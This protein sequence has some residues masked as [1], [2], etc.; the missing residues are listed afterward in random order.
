MTFLKEAS[1]NLV[2]FFAT[3]LPVNIISWLK[4]GRQGVRS[5]SLYETDVGVKYRHAYFDSAR[6]SE[7][8][9]DEFVLGSLDLPFSDFL[10]PPDLLRNAYTNCGKSILESPHYQL[11]NELESGTFSEAGS[12]Y[13]RRSKSGTLD[14]RSPVNVDP[15][16]IREK[17]K[18]RK[19]E[20]LR[21]GYLTVTVFRLCLK[22]RSRYVIAD[23]KHRI[24]MAALLSCPQQLLLRRIS[25]RFSDDPFF[26]RIYSFI[27][28]LEPNDYS[29]NQQIIKAI[30]NES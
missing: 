25:R 27:L 15:K 14:A 3:G 1:S 30:L 5:P 11:M 16:F 10:M 9:E 19:E 12:N 24:A 4:R 22:Q 6:F 8:I 7:Y 29:I 23:G 2:D 13:L 26:H 17:F 20:L 28:T 21:G 18:M